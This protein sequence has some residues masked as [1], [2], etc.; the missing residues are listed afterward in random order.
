MS[1]LCARPRNNAPMPSLLIQLG[2]H[3]A[4]PGVPAA[5]EQA[6]AALRAGW[7]VTVYLYGDGA[8]L[9]DEGLASV[10]TAATNGHPAIWE[11]WSEV[12]TAGAAIWVNDLDF[13]HRGRRRNS[14]LGEP[15]LVSADVLIAHLPS[16]DHVLTY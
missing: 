3:D 1:D 13:E 11:T 4:R 9:V 15:G 8:Y 16:F 14:L 7:H 2:S 12:V 6:L 10:L 5:L